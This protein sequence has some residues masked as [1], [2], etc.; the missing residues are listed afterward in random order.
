MNERE[1]LRK[2]YNRTKDRQLS[3]WKLAERVK[4]YKLKRNEYSKNCRK[5]KREAWADKIS[6]LEKISE[7]A[8]MQKFLESSQPPKVG[9][10][11]KND[12]SFTSSM[13]ESIRE[14]MKHSF[15]NCEE[16]VTNATGETP[17]EDHRVSFLDDV[18]CEEIDNTL[19]EGKVEWAINSMSP[20][21]SPG[22]D[23][24]FPALLQKA[25]PSVIEPLRALFR[26]SLVMGYIPVS[27]RDTFVTFIPK[28]GKAAYDQAK[29]YRPISLMSFVLKVL[30]KLLDRRIREKHLTINSFSTDQF[31]YQKDKG[32]D[33]ALHGL[34]TQI[35]KNLKFGEITFAVFLDIEGAFDN[36]AFH[37]IERTA[38]EKEINQWIV[39]W[40][41]SMLRNR[42]VR[43]KVENDQ[44]IYKPTRGCPQGGCLSPLLWSLVIDPL[45]IKLKKNGF[46]VSG[47]VDDLVILVSGKKSRINAICGRLNWAL[48]IVE[49]WCNDTGLNVNP[50]KTNYMIFSKSKIENQNAI[51][52][53]GKAVERTETFKYLGVHLDSK[54]SWAHHIEKA[55]EK[56]RKALWATKKMITTK[57]GLGP[58]QMM[59]VYKQIVI[60]RIS[61][62]C[63]VWWHASYKTK[64]KVKLKSLQRHATMLI[65]GAVKSTPSDALEALLS[66]PSL[67]TKL[68]SI[69]LKTCTRLM[70]VGLW[71]DASF[72][73]TGHRKFQD[74]ARKLLINEYSDSVPLEWHV[75]SKYKVTINDRRQ[76]HRGLAIRGNSHCWVAI[77]SL[78]DSKA[79]IALVNTN[80]GIQVKKKGKRPLRTHSS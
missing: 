33:A 36:T 27:W 73:E 29:S 31:A 13:T 48:K 47:Y 76:W 40:I 58:T 75:N 19:S 62:G 39:T 35:E 79:G 43:S 67:E 61:Y 34:V 53:Y 28:A 56:G 42:I 18:S 41:N 16:G 49:M 66:L 5:A 10:I 26:S 1:N 30:E 23:G 3:Q 57:W 52:L 4:D 54:L 15:P 51:K 46:K 68:E 72:P 9:S 74:R 71:N 21:K 20:Y 14:L 24:I 80:L 55:V 77:G 6:K 38:H 8:R 12:G 60:P 17:L 11:R 44:N 7:I 63:T 59:W 25:G 2:S 78:S 45:L 65:T 32:T 37:I 69:A 22:G 70:K 50:D 64:H